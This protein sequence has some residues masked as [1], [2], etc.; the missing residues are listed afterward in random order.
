MKGLLIIILL[1]TCQVLKAQTRLG[2]N[3]KQI[4]DEY[5][6]IDFLK[7]T[8]S[9]G[10]PFLKNITDNYTWVYLF[11]EDGI[12]RTNFLTPDSKNIYD[13]AIKEL[14]ST[15]EKIGELKWRSYYEGK[16]IITYAV[17]EDKTNSDFFIIKEDKVKQSAK[18]SKESFCY[19]NTDGTGKSLDTIKSTL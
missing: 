16:P 15:K 19:F 6:N 18:E 8:T 12:C 10:Q 5:P 7:G 17:H 14:N 11:D 3:E 1:I 13:Q 2:Y 4:R 9:K